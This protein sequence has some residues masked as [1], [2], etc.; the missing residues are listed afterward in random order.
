MIVVCPGFYHSWADKNINTDPVELL[1]YFKFAECVV[2]DTFHGCVMSLISRTDMAV[3]IR[4]NANKLVNLLEEY[5]LLDRQL[6]ESMK[7]DDIFA[8]KIDW[9]KTNLQITQRRKASMD[10]LKEMIAK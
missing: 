10:Y 3:I 2:T 6:N 1:R 9:K 8:M 5:E 4:D 7:L